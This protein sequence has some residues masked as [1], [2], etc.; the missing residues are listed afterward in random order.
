MVEVALWSSL[1]SFAG[2]ADKVEVEGETV[3]EILDALV[4]AHPGLAPHIESGV[5]VAIDGRIIFNSLSEPVR[6]D[7]EVVLLQQLKGG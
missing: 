7:S 5:S 1:R 6:P 4:K 2:G 3:G